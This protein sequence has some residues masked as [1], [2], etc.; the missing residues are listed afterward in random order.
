LDQELCPYCGLDLKK[1]GKGWH[2]S[3]C[4]VFVSSW[5]LKKKRIIDNEEE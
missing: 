3:Y 2:C 4:G 1:N 5:D